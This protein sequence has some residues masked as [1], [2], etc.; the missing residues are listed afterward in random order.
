MRLIYENAFSDKKQTNLEF[1]K[2]SN[3]PQ[4]EYIEELEALI[5]AEIQALHRYACY[6]LGSK[7]E[8]EDVIQEL[9]LKLRSQPAG[10]I[11]NLKHYLFRALTNACTQRLRNQRKINFVD[12]TQLSDLS[13]NDLE[14]VSFEQEQVLIERLLATIPEEQSEVIRLHLHA[15]CQFQEVAD[16]MQIPLPT[17]KSRYRYGI[18]HLREA[19]RR[20]GLL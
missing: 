13:S 16:I 19:M 11:A 3:D 2:F 18:E 9:Y 1:M 12:I 10:K 8:A 7:D 20:E 14:A 4:K 6:R 5:T 15:G 17:A